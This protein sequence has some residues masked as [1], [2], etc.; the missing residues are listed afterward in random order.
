MSRPF[1]L[2]AGGRDL[3]GYVCPWCG[4]KTLTRAG[5]E[6]HFEADPRCKGNRNVNNPTQTKYNI[7]EPE[8]SDE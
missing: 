5:L 3:P 6:A 4:T 2:L 8:P 7:G 1:E